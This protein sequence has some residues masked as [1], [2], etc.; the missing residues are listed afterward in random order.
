MPE[1]WTDGA[2]DDYSIEPLRKYTAERGRLNSSGMMNWLRCAPGNRLS[3]NDPSG[4]RT[5]A[6]CSCGPNVSARVFHGTFCLYLW[7]ARPDS[8]TVGNRQVP[9]LDSDTPAAVIVPTGVVHAY[10]NVDDEAGL[11][12]NCLNQLYAGEGKTLPIDKIPC[13]DLVNSLFVM[14]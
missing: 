10:R 3:V 14:E 12:I 8:P 1:H 9:E 13:E 4:Y 6:S 7:D 5:W 11:P 2:I